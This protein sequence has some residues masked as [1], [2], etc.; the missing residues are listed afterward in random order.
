MTTG[1]L[2]GTSKKMNLVEDV[3]KEIGYSK[4]KTGI[5]YYQNGNF[6]L[7]IQISEICHKERGFFF[8][9]PA[10]KT[11]MEFDDLSEKFPNNPCAIEI[12]KKLNKTIPN[13]LY[14][15]VFCSKSN[16]TPIRNLETLFEG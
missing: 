9:Y 14:R 8:D 16:K 1:I 12:L 7:R 3:L 6:D 10:I 11:Q 13:L 15:K 2:L 4:E 5:Y